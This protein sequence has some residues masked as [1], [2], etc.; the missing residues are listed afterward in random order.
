MKEYRWLAYSASQGVGYCKY[1][2]WFPQATKKVVPEILVKTP[3]RNSSKAKGKD[4]YLTTHDA[5]DYPHNAMVMV[6]AFLHTYNQPDKKIENVL[7]KQRQKLSDKN[8]HIMC[9]IANTV[10]LCGM[11][12]LPLIGHRDD[13][14]ADHAPNRGNFLTI[15]EHAAKADPILNEHLFV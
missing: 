3:F 15:L 5:L 6:E 14:T 2:V 10:I 7:D 11:Q 4:G 9:V 1:C 8:K 13:S 12:G